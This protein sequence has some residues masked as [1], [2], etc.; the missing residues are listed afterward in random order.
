MKYDF[1]QLTD[2]TGTLSYKWEGIPA[3]FP[4][5]PK[6]VPFWI[7]DMEFPC[8]EPIVRAVRGRA[9]HPLYGYSH[10][11]EDA[12]RLT[13]SW[14]RRRHGWEVDPEW[15]IFSGGVVPG[16][17]AMMNAVTDP[18]DKVILQPPVYYPLQEMIRDN[19]RILVENPLLYDGGRWV[20][21]EDELER[22]ASDPGTK[23]F[24]LCNPHNPVSRAYTR[25]EL[26][27]AGEICLAHGV[28]IA[29][30]EIHADIVYRGHRHT[31]IASLSRELAAVTMTSLSC[32]KTF[33]TAG[34]QLSTGIIPDRDLRERVNRKLAASQYLVNL[35]GAVGL[36]AA[37]GDPECEDYLEQLLVY[38]WDN[39]LFLDAFL[40]SCMPGIKCQR[41]EATYLVWL[42]CRGLGLS[43]AEIRKLF[44]VNAG[45]AP[46]FGPMFGTGSSGFVRLNIA[47][48]RKMLQDCLNRLAEAYQQLHT[49]GML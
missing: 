3:E 17:I 31:P 33:N 30:D 19:G 38:L 27:R 20:M 21:N 9:G 23:L 43:D 45:I 28:K 37:Y 12:R 16:L 6:A 2:R 7:A 48:P 34:L 13:A 32:S 5:N 18:G 49:G 36:Q 11:S 42:D 4:E 47:C 44:L 22:L 29:S 40:R 1:D 46:D 41:P 10:E 39:Y 26:T 25:R 24:V 14:L 35:F 15:I 8:P